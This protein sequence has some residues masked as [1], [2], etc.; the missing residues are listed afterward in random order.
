[1]NNFAV[2]NKSSEYPKWRE[3]VDALKAFIAAH[4]DIRC[5][6]QSLSVPE[7]LR[8]KF[9]ELV[10]QAQVGLTTDCVGDRFDDLKEIAQKCAEVRESLL[11]MSG[12]EEFRLTSTLENFLADPVA[13]LAKPSFDIVLDA[14]QTDASSEEIEKKAQE[15]LPVFCNMIFR[16]AYESWAYY[17]IIAALKPK[18][19]YAMLSPNT[20]DVHAVESPSITIG[21]QITSPER[22]IPEAVFETEEGSIFAMKSEVARELDFYGT[23]I[24]RRR[25]F[26]AGGNTVDQNGHRV[27]L[28]YKLEALDKIGLIADRDEQ[29]IRAS[30]LMCEVLQA[31]EMAQV[32]YAVSF[33]DR[34]DAVRSKRPVQVLV[35]DDSAQFPNDILTKGPLPS[36][37]RRVVGKDEEELTKIALLLN[38]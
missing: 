14:I 30:D 36:F 1:M 15:K 19:F 23:K 11:S 22:R 28:L 9:Y 16:N 10:F 29:Y 17:G 37:E 2:E 7:A 4:S 5:T 26:S 32:S 12:L 34:I 20:I 33:F 24:T 27:L 3:S 13:T 31:E 35:M 25:D 21:S 38:D 6:E 8:D 18:K